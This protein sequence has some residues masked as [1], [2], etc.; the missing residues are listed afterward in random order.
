MSVFLLCENNLGDESKHNPVSYR[1][2]TQY[3]CIIHLEKTVLS[4]Q[5]QQPIQK[6][7]FFFTK[8][9]SHGMKM[10]CDKDQ[11]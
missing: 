6:G 5:I 10:S 3:K 8:L 9:G 1:D 11:I 4:K 2:V 7:F